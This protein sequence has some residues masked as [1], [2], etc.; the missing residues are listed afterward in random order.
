MDNNYDGFADVINENTGIFGEEAASMDNGLKAFDG[1]RTVP[2][3]DGV[4]VEMHCRS[5]GNPVRITVEWGEII[6]IK[7][8][9]AP[10]LAYRGTKDL[11]RD[12]TEWGFSPEQQAWIPKNTCG[13]CNSVCAPQFKPEEAEQ[14][15][16]V[17]RRNSWFSPRYEQMAATR[18]SQVVQSMQQQQQMARR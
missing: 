7:Y 3:P 10:Q 4:Y 15:L 13:R 2:K 17:A 6:A 9:V 16:A 11:V 12:I 5:C 18:C 14:H 8:N 1:A